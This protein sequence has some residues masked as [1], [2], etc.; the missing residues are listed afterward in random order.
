[1][2]KCPLLGKCSGIDRELLS[3]YSDT[4]LDVY[5]SSEQYRFNHVVC[6][7]KG[8][9]KGQWSSCQK[10]NAERDLHASNSSGSSSSGKSC[11]VATC[12]YGSYDCPE[13]RVLRRFRDSKLL[14]SWFGR[15][16]VRVYYA[17]SPKIVKW[18]GNKVWFNKLWKPIFDKIIVRLLKNGIAP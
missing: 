7:D 3:V 18:F 12:V 1:M 6:E 8:N 10:Y 11:Y 17:T 5:L 4:N 14:Q 13:V 9:P 16:L 2:A 15:Q